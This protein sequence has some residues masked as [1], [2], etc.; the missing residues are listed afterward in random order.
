[1]R[2]KYVTSHYYPEGYLPT[3]TH[4]N[5][6][7]NSNSNINSTNSENSSLLSV[8]RLKMSLGVAII[9]SG[10]FVQDEH[11]VLSQSPSLQPHPSNPPPFFSLLSKQPPTSPSKQSTPALSNPHKL[12]LSPLTS[13]LT[14]RDLGKPTMIC[15]CVATFMQ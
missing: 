15:S 2:R 8:S 14:T 12:F 10:I 11:L 9:G 6:H 3:K 7:S 4:L 1:M 13:I 5:R